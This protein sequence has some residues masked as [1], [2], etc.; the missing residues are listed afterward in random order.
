MAYDENLA[1]RILLLLKSRA[2]DFT[3]R[4]MK[5]MIF[6][7]AKGLRS[8]RRLEAWVERGVAFAR[9]LLAK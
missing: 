2:M 8:A 1:E 4:P 3:G 9:S 7:D 6:V 5:G